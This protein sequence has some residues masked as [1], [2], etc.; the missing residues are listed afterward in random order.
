MKFTKIPELHSWWKVISLIGQ[1]GLIY[2]SGN[3]VCYVNIDNISL[4]GL[5]G[6][7]VCKAF[8]VLSA[9]LVHFSPI[10]YA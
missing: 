10:C 5:F 6:G 9:V 1:L 7:G 2:L 3:I 8:L 4:S